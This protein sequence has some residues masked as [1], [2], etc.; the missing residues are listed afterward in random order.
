MNGKIITNILFFI[1]LNLLINTL[2][3]KETCSDG[4]KC[5]NVCCKYSKQNK[6]YCCT[7]VSACIT[8]NGKCAPTNG[9][10]PLLAGE[11]N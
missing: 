11:K 5:D 7:T 8:H 10:V 9:I 6:Y 2:M 4:T 3:A 1:L